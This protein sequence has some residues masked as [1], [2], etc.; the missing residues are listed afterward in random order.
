MGMQEP[1]MGWLLVVAVDCLAVVAVGCLPVAVP[2]YSCLQIEMDLMHHY[3]QIRY[4]RQ[5]Y[6]VGN[7]HWRLY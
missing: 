7:N 2:S 5:L 1:G 6:H 3:T 4:L